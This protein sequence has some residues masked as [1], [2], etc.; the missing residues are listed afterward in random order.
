MFDFGMA[1]EAQREAIQTVDGPVLITAG[2]GTGKTFTLVQRVIYMI[3]EKKIRPEQ[4]L[5][6][7]YTDKAAKELIT[8][9]SNALLERNIPVNL[10]DMYIGTIH[11]ICLRLLKEYAQY[12]SITKNFQLLDRFEQKYIVMLESHRFKNLAGHD[13]VIHGE[14]PIDRAGQICKYMDQLSE[15][16]VDPEK[17]IRDPDQKI[18][19]MGRLLKAYCAMLQE[20][21]F[22][23]FT[24][25]QTVVYHMFLDNPQLLQTVREKIKYLMIDEYQDT[26]YIQ[27]Q[28]V[29]LLAGENGNLCVVGDDDQ[30]LYRFRGTSPQNILEFRNKFSPGKCR[31]ISLTVNY[32][33]DTQIVDFYN[34]WMNTPYAFQ[35]ENFRIPKQITA[36]SGISANSPAVIRLGS[37]GGSKA[38]CET[39]LKFIRRLQDSGKLEDLNQIAFIF[40]SVRA[41]KS[42]DISALARYLESNGIHVFS[43][44]SND[45]FQ[46][47]EIKMVIGALILMFSCYYDKLKGRSFQRN[48]PALFDY[49]DD[50][51]QTL[52]SRVTG[53]AFAPVRAFINSKY[54]YHRDLKKNAGY[55][56]ADLLYQLFAFE[57]FAGMLKPNMNAGLLEQRQTRNLAKFTE[58]LSRFEQ[59]HYAAVITPGKME[60]KTVNLFNCYLKH[61]YEEGLGEYEGDSPYAPSGSVAFLTIHQAKGMEFPVVITGMPKWGPFTKD[62]TTIDLISEKYYHR[63]PFEPREQISTFDFWR[64]YYTA[65]S[66]AQ[67]L[68]VLT[69][70]EDTGAPCIQMRE[71]YRNLASCD[72]PEFDPTAFDFRKVKGAELKN[73]YSFTSHISIY[74]DCPRYYMF[75]RELGFTPAKVGTAMFGQIVHQTIEDVN[76]AALRGQPHLITRDNIARWL[77]TNY[78]SLSETEHSYLSRDERQRVLDHVLRYVKRQSENGGWSQLREAEV[79]VTLMKPGYIIEGT[80]DLIRGEG[81]TVEL[82]DFKSD[83]HPDFDKNGRRLS[84]YRQQLELYAY[85]VEQ[86]TGHTVTRLHL[87]YTAV[88]QGDPQ[89]TFPADRTHID[90]TIAEFDRI[91]QR[92]G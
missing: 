66:R 54:R 5:I 59:L 55:G 2:P 76:K 32:R 58:L 78:R 38:W 37:R 49:Y 53:E 74:E 25:L 51:I 4:I 8:R 60:E 39:V 67:N 15:E 16:L 70:R 13:C 83:R 1:N 73:T 86:K 71:M 26:N 82:V 34:H 12:S 41:Q 92:I 62:P 21:K 3:Q 61:L 10:K 77:E 47:E 28:L 22:L 9:I 79:T 11:S 23:D 35:W 7:T 87:Y 64:T 27:E 84:H 31:R 81:D 91:V 89:V 72:A 56:F 24:H 52:R 42:P 40:N 46:R 29:F 17:L 65:F 6:A 20:K 80:V 43:P 63:T 19:A 85:L 33:S 90:Q 44:R 45:Y 88:T 50:C 75:S 30:S 68:L 57:P 18:A 14:T 48:Y 69:A 36:G